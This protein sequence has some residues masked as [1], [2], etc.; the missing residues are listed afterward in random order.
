[1]R[2][3]LMSRRGTSP[4]A[5]LRLLFDAVAVDEIAGDD[6][7]QD[8]VGALADDHERG[9]AVVA[10]DGELFG[11]AVAAVNAHGLHGDLVGHLAGK[12]LGHAGFEVEALAGIL[13][14]RGVVG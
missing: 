13:L 11:V 2:Y 5:T 3:L 6:G 1:M 12:E 9:I 7:L 14:L 4:R 8:L 10:L